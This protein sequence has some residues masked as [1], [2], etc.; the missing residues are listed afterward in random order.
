MLY[1]VVDTIVTFDPETYEEF[2]RISRVE[3]NAD[4]LRLGIVQD[5]YWDDR[6]KQLIIRPVTVCPLMH[7]L[8]GDGNY[9]Y[10]RPLFYR[11]MK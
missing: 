4:Y 7:Q 6:R 11:K 8:D 1:Q 2:V 3:M 5:W 10:S 9:L